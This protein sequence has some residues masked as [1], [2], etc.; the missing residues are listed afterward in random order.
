LLR[1]CWSSS[2]E[3]GLE[4]VD[5]VEEAKATFGVVSGL[6]KSGVRDCRGDGFKRG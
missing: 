3:A 5:E 2:I 4:L 1:G 6:D